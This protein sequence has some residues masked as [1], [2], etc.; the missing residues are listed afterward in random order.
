M[1]AWAGLIF[2]ACTRLSS[3]PFRAVV[4]LAVF[5]AASWAISSLFLAVA[6]SSWAFS[7]GV[8]LPPWGVGDGSPLGVGVVS[9][10]IR[11]GVSASTGSAESSSGPRLGQ[12]GLS[13]PRRARAFRCQRPG[14]GLEGCVGGQASR[15]FMR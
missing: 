11:T 1:A 13:L 8:M 2:L 10:R 12:A 4:S 5:W 9:W 3:L 6:W 15:L 7:S 14:V